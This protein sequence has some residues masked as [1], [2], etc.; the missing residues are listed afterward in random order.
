MRFRYLTAAT[1]AA[2]SLAGATGAQAETVETVA[3]GLDNPRSV[4]LAP[5]GTLYVANA[6]SGGK[7]C[8]GRGEQ[9]QCF[10]MTGRIVKFKDGAVTNQTTG[11]ASIAG[12]DGT[13]AQGV[14]GV[15]VAPD[16]GLF[17]VT[18]STVPEMVRALPKQARRQTGRLFD[19]SGSKPKALT[20]VDK[21]EWKSNFDN[22]KGDINSNPYAVL[23]TGSRVIIV[24]AGA[25]TLYEYR[26]RTAKKFAVIP[27]NG[28]KGQP[29]PSAIAQGPDGAVYV[30]ELAESA[31]QGKARVFRI[32][33]RGG[34]PKVHAKGFTGITGL[35]FGP[36]GSMYVTELGLTSETFQG[37]VVRVA[38]DG[39]RTTLGAGKLTAPQ[40]AAVDANGAVYVSTGSVFPATT[41][42]QGPFGGQG[43]TLS[44]IVP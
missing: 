27:K 26:N 2:A 32:P 44:K 4:A 28:K 11:F 10:G 3:T 23:A 5:D 29:V 40:G 43:G 42:K 7:N 30:G 12:P 8:D 6:G 22:V 20:Q 21:L 19:V 1:V 33:A 18:G 24:D 14:H 16:G 15:S 38:P 39:T 17:A 37:D 35:A 13:F 25:N 9:R 36:D 31:G 34:K 41:P